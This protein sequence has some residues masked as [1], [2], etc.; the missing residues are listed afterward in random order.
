MGHLVL[1]LCMVL[2]VSGTETGYGATGAGRSSPRNSGI[3]T[4][5]MTSCMLLRYA[6]L[7]YRMLLRYASASLR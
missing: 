1:R 7:T 3:P 4:Y 5:C 2:W 6:L